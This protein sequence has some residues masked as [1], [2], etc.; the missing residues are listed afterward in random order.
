M[1]PRDINLQLLDGGDIVAT[2]TSA[3]VDTE[4]GFF[5]VIRAWLGTCTGTTTTLIATIQA[6]IDGGSN[7][8]SI[9][10]LP[11]LDDA[12]D[13]IVVGRPVYI[14]KPT[15]SSTVTRTK[16][17]ISY[18]VTG[19]TPVFPITAYIEPLLSLAPQATDVSLAEGVAKLI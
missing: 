2:G 4:G 3:V 6:S 17:R 16:V 5:A 12:D 19:T 7:Y 1:S 9:G 10:V 14:P 8:Y 18:A 13:D 15:L 11:T